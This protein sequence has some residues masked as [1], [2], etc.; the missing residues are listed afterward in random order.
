MDPCFPIGNYILNML[1]AGWAKDY[2]I[3]IQFDLR[4]CAPSFRL[5]NRTKQPRVRNNPKAHWLPP[6]IPLSRLVEPDDYVPISDCCQSD[7]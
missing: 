2:L 6:F 1:T 7:I 5:L 3:D 4:N